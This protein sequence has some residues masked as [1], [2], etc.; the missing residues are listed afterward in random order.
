MIDPVFEREVQKLQPKIAGQDGGGAVSYIPSRT[1]RVGASFD[2][3]TSLRSCPRGLHISFCVTPALPITALF[4]I[5]AS[6]YFPRSCHGIFRRTIWEFLKF[7]KAAW[8]RVS[9]SLVGS[10]LL[11][12][13]SWRPIWLMTLNPRQ[14][15]P[16]SL[17]LRGKPHLS[18]GQAKSGSSS[19]ICAVGS[20]PRPVRSL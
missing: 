17:P 12:G 15:A 3:G 16:P 10:K 13:C 8:Y 11:G 14:R 6:S 18:R 9:G 1:G 20:N 4:W 19:G 5:N 2:L 7:P